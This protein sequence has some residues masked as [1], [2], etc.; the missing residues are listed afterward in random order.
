MKLRVRLYADDLLPPS[1]QP[2]NYN[3]THHHV[4]LEGT[5][6]NHARVFLQCDVVSRA[7]TDI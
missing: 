1:G 2:V 5:R 6:N 7:V 3:I 4:T